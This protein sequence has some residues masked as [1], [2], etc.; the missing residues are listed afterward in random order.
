MLFVNASSAS[1]LSGVQKLETCQPLSLASRRG[2]VS[3]SR[4]LSHTHTSFGKCH[5]CGPDRRWAL[6]LL[7]EAAAGS[8]EKS[9]EFTIV[10]CN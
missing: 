10:S 4:P 5:G 6:L 1:C 8:E 9:A 7:T 3:L 2:F